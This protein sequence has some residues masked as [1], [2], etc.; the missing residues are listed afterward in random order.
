MRA[1]V[2]EWKG[3]ADPQE[4]YGK[5]RLE[6][7]TLHL[8][9]VPMS[10]GRRRA[11]VRERTTDDADT[12]SYPRRSQTTPFIDDHF[13]DPG[14][15]RQKCDASR[16]DPQTRPHPRGGVFQPPPRSDTRNHDT[17]GE[18]GPLG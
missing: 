4:P 16:E 6:D 18:V 14:D 13:T 11:A 15:P 17:R 3:G 7:E 2:G 9:G 1:A 12:R 10:L 8:Y 5:T